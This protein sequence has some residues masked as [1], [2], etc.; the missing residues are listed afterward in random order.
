MRAALQ[1]Q[2]HLASTS[3]HGNRLATRGG[4]GHRNRGSVRLNYFAAAESTSPEMATFDASAGAN[5]RALQDD[6]DPG[7]HTKLSAKDRFVV[8]TLAGYKI[9]GLSVGGQ[10]TCIVLPQLKLIFDSGRCPQRCVY[11]ETMCLSHT[12]MD[13]VGG[14]G[15]Y[16]AT[17]NLLQLNP[18]TILLPATRVTAFA[19][20]IDALRELDG[21]DMPYIAA[22]MSPTQTFE[23]DFQA[24]D[25]SYRVTSNSADASTP[26]ENTST[27]NHSHKVSKTITIKAFQTTHPVPSQGY[28]VYSTREKLKQEFVGKTGQEIKALKAGGVEITDQVSI[29]EVAFTGDTTSDW[30]DRGTVGVDAGDGKYEIDTVASDALRA[31]LLICE[32]TFV[33][34]KCS[35]SDARRYGHTHLAELIDRQLCFQNEA[36]LLIHFSARYKK[37][38]IES[39]LA[40][41]LPEKLRNIVTPMVVGFG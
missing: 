2:V 35:V 32:C 1:T 20:F 29:P 19:K 3:G 6:A 12:H 18:P 10:E 37:E 40:E 5:K 27:T 36:I 25:S 41:K 38:E 24:S 26:E 9:E 11:A 14:C 21:S 4:A 34:D 7:P 31:K 8:H 17:R 30:I 16:I 13:H 28:V 23:T 33:D 15:F 39:A 22:P